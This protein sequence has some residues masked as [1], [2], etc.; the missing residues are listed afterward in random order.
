MTVILFYCPLHSL[1]VVFGQTYPERIITD[2]EERRSQSLQ[3]VARVR[4]E[5]QQ[6]VDKR[7]GCDLVP[8]P[9]SLVTKALGLSHQDSSVV[10][11]GKQFLL[12][13]ITRMEF[14]YQ[15]ENP[16]ADASSNP[17]NA[18]LKGYVSR[19]RD[20]TIAFLNERD[21]TASVMFEAVQRKERLESDH[22]RIEGLPHAPAPRGSAR[23]TPTA[24]D[25]FSIV[26]GGALTSL[27]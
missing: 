22:R 26:P 18:L 14:K 27:R 19:K 17:Y 10:I 25:T 23:R 2:L 7:T 21:F 15:Q 5:F 24:K 12:P 4:R 13:V 9:P 1:G 8:L 11:E 6:Y 16:N 20:E 3:D